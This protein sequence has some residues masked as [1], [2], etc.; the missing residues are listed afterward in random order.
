MRRSRPSA[1]RV[2]HE[3]AHPA[4]LPRLVPYQC[5]TCGHCRECL[6]N[7]RGDRIF[8][9]KFT[10]KEPELRSIPERAE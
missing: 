3:I 9:E 10:S 6:D 7:A 5:C 2:F 4:T 8:A 1:F